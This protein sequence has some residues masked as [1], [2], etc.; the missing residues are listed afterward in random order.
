[1]R[2]RFGRALLAVPVLLYILLPTR[3]YY[4]DGLA[5]AIN[6]EGFAP[7]RQTIHPNHLIYTVSTVWLYRAVLAAGIPIRALFLMQLVNG[8]LAGAAVLLVYRALRRRPLSTESALAG[9][10]LFAFAATWWRFATDANAYVPSVFLVLCANDL[11]EEDRSRWG[12]GLAHAGAMLF[13]ELAIFYVPVVWLRCKGWRDRIRYTVAALGP[14][15][16]AYLFAYRAVFGR[17]DLR[18]F[19]HWIV[20]YTPDAGF[21]FQ[22]VR[23]FLLTLS[24]TLRLFAGGKIGQAVPGVLTAAGILLLIATMGAIAYRFRRPR[25]TRPPRDLVLWATLYLV[26]LFFWMPQNTFYRLFYL[27]PLVLLFAVSLRRIAPLVTAALFLWNGIF[28]I[29]PQSRV[30][31]NAP[32]AFALAEHRRWPA[33][34]PIVFHRFH[35]DLW[36]ISY[37]NQQASWIGLPRID[38][39]VLDQGLAGAREQHQPLW[40]EATAY[41]FLSGDSAGRQWIERHRDATPPIEW[42]DAKHA[43]RFYPMR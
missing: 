35:P 8:L 3:N 21:S 14:V 22:P 4:W 37:F 34:T 32:L 1:M 39:A 20:A 24:G 16:I 7:L 15:A 17:F 38:F 9:A 6:V 33:G 29:Y 25:F 5:F 19:L 26:F 2:V 40:L 42:T 31:S 12:A 30:E 10:L 13:H 28:L 41:E 18:G 23:N 43:F 36:T 11:I 27:A